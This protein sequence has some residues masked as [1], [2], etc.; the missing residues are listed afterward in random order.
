MHFRSWVRSTLVWSLPVL[1]IGAQSAAGS[2]IPHIERRGSTMQLIVDDKPFLVLGGEVYN[3]SSMSLDSMT[4]LWPRF[5]ALHLNTVLAPVSWAMLEKS[6]G[7]F[8]Y[9]M[10]DGLVRDARAHDLR[11][12]LLWFG[13][14]K[15]TWS[16]YAPDWVKR[17]F[18]RFPR[19]QLRNGAAT[20][21][22]SPFSDA[23]RDADARAFAALM[24]RIREIDGDAHTVIMVQVENEVGM[25][26]D[27]RDYSP[28]ANAA[29]QQPV[30]QQLMDYL[31][32]HKDTL[33]PKLSAKWQA[34]GLKTAGNWEA[35]FGPGL[36]TEDLFMAWHY[37]RY[38]DK[39]AEA[40]KA[41]YNMPMFTNAALIRGS[42]A[43]GQFNSGGPL[44][45]SM[46]V[47]KA[48]AP[49]LDFLAPDIYFEFKKWSAEY[50]R[51][52]NPLFV[53]ETQGGARGG[54]CAFYAVGRHSALGFSP[55]GIDWFTRPEDGDARLSRNYEVLAQL[56][57]L[58][59]EN[60]PKGRVTA[61]L[62]D[63]PTPSQKLQLGDFTLDV[64]A[65]R[66][67]RNSPDR[68]E[69]PEEPPLQTPYG[70]F[71]ATGPDEF[72][73]AGAGLTVRF[74]PN[75]PGPSFAGLATVEEGSFVDG[76][77]HP[78]RTLAGDDT[79]QGNSVSLRGTAGPGILRVVLYRYR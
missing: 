6:E 32:K 56:A 70:I 53:P 42:Y 50:D 43:P 58:V 9:S 65:T 59:L 18:E 69:Y 37:A 12:V 77:W 10:L 36:E 22:L 44:P 23:C 45:H 72:Y 78:G 52:D 24:R 7:K 1:A 62:L 29:Y 74:S 54:A 71:V 14:W 75:S 34:A 64:S 49:Q 21:R 47:W 11:L 35:V 67:W 16:S 13:S 51:S 26:P 68:P 30:P 66:P 61:V 48:A 19:A 33:H 8:D 60:Q 17:D 38:I 79:E 20:E 40:G 55:F 76:R 3:N 31:S 25:I 73:L 63:E 4:P 27:A 5:R 15:N 39:V 57:P 46:D 41:Q 2:Q 28:T